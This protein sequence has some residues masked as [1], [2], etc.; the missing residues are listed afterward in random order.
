MSL[1]QSS[2]KVA[3][4]A[5]E[6]KMRAVELEEKMSLDSLEEANR[7]R[8]QRDLQS[9][10]NLLESMRIKHEELSHELDS[11]TAGYHTQVADRSR[12]LNVCQEA[13]TVFRSPVLQ[14][15]KKKR[16][17]PTQQLFKSLSQELSRFSPGLSLQLLS[18]SS[19]HDTEETLSKAKSTIT[20][21]ITKLQNDEALDNRHHMLCGDS[22][23]NVDLH[24]AVR[25]LE[26]AL[27][28]EK[29]RVRTLRRDFASAK[30]QTGRDLQQGAT[31]MANAQ[32][33]GLLTH[34]IIS[35]LKEN[36]A[37]DGVE[38]QHVFLRVVDLLESAQSELRKQVEATEKEGT[39][40]EQIL[41]RY[42]EDVERE[43]AES[44][45][46][47]KL[48]AALLHQMECDLARHPR[49]ERVTCPTRGKAAL[50][51]TSARANRIQA[52]QGAL[53]KLSGG[54]EVIV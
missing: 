19:Q 34:R 33:A 32:N 52:L 18:W 51:K 9:Y 3:L 50:M 49:E 21:I 45:D 39:V 25:G 46:A 48:D 17:S 8:L 42:Q 27:E 26:E 28:K 24:S 7:A 4:Q 29:T 37:G 15:Q 23:S 12:E 30:M 10:K 14:G 13:L 20:N 22:T 40:I 1:V 43:L 11:R 54:R 41:N 16:V 5:A 2:M 38:S 6:E 31:E 35:V 44:S 47:L 36:S 53:E